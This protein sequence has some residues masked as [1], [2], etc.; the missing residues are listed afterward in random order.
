[1]TLSDDSH[2]NSD[3]DSDN[4]RM[5]TWT[6][7][8]LEEGCRWLVQ[9]PRVGVTRRWPV[10]IARTA[11]ATMGEACRYMEM[12]CAWRHKQAKWTKGVTS[13]NRNTYTVDEPTNDYGM[14][15]AW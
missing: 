5:V 6:R 12:L 2:D 8:I 15:G 7:I 14:G 13:A 11:R 3:N 9:S 4:T 1:M 10:G